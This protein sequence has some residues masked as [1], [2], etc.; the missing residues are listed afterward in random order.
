[1]NTG[2]DLRRYRVKDDR[3]I[4][5]DDTIVIGW[6]GTPNSFRY[7]QSLEDAFRQLS[8]RYSIELRVI[9][10]I[11]YTSSS[12]KV[13]NRRW[14]LD[15]EVDDLC[16]FDIGIMPLCDDEWARGKSGYKAVQYMA[17]GIPAVCS[18]V[19]VTTEIVQDGARGFLASTTAEWVDK[20][21]ALIE[22]PELRRR[23]GRAGRRA[24]ETAYS[25]QA[26][27]PRL[28]AILQGLANGGAL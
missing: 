10:S 2:V 15:T 28:V 13:G 1:V 12:V 26:V 16:A 24:V 3:S 19:G 11:D 18:P 25:I 21:A 5:N 7:L 27:A 17:V 9:S 6:M 14:S 8:R 4:N 22:S 20:L 23:H